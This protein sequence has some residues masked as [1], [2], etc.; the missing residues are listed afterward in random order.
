MR[1]YITDYLEI[2][3]DE[4]NALKENYSKK[5]IMKCSEE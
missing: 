3:S 1:K 2:S 5:V 4:E